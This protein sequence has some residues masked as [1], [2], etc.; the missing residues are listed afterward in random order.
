MKLIDLK[1]GDS[2]TGYYLMRNIIPKRT[3][4]NKPYLSMA[5]TDVSASVE[6]MVWDSSSYF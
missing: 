4:T 3:K 5:L 2:F 6:S 1:P